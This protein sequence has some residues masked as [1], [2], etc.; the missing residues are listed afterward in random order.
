[1]SFL[2][3]TLPLSLLLAAVLVGLVI[4]HARRGGFD[5]WEGPAWRHHFDDDQAPELDASREE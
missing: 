1:V 5:D 3:L 4:A 2:A